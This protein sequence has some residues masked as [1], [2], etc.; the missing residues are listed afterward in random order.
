MSITP[1]TKLTDAAESNA[2]DNYHLVFAVR[3]ALELLNFSADGLKALSLEGVSKDDEKT[4]DPQSLLGVDLTEYYGGQNLTGAKAVVISQ[5]KYSTRHADRAWTAAELCKGKKSGTAG[6]VMDRLGKLFSE[7][8][9]NHPAQVKKVRV[10]LVSNRPVSTDLENLVNTLK[11]GKMPRSFATYKNKLSVPDKN[12]ADRIHK[13]T[14][15]SADQILGFLAA[16]DFSDCGSGS[17]LYQTER[18]YEAIAR[19]GDLDGATQFAKLKDLVGDRMLPGNKGNHTLY[20]TDVLYKFNFSELSDLLPVR[21]NIEIPDKLVEREQ[22]ND[23]QK[24]ILAPATK[25]LGL[26]GHAGIGKSTMM[27]SI[28]ALLPPGSKGILFDCYG[29]GAYNDADDRRHTPEYAI[30]QLCNEL[31]LKCGTPFL[32]VR[33]TNTGHLLKELKKRLTEAVGLLQAVSPGAL[34]A[35]LIDAADNSVSAAAQ[36]HTECFVTE[37]ARMG[38]PDGCRVI[39]SARTERLSTLN[40]PASAPTFQIRPFTK[41]ETVAFLAK[42]FS[43]IPPDTVTEFLQLTYG[44]PRVMAYVLEG[45]GSSLQE[46]IEFLK[47]NGKTLD[48]LFGQRIQEAQLRSGDASAIERFLRALVA[49]PS[50]V[51]ES[52]LQ[53]VSGLSNDL[54]TDLRVD[55][56][57]GL[58][59]ENGVFRFRDEDFETFL[60][61][62][63][64]VTASDYKAI[65]GILITEA[66][67][68]DYAS[69]HLGSMLA[70]AGDKT[71]LVD[72]VIDRKFLER[73]AD[74]IKN[75]EVFIE[76]VRL[77]M[78]MTDRADLEFFKLQFIAAEAAKSNELIENILIGH[79]ELAAAYGD[80]QT[81]QKLYFQ[82]GNPRWYGPA[83]FRN[84]AVF[85]R[86]KGTHD[87]ARKHLERARSW[88]NYRARLKEEE[89]DDYD[90]SGKDIAYAAEATLRVSGIDRCAKFIDSW[91]P[92][93]FGFEVFEELLKLLIA[94]ES[95]QQL[96]NWL[97]KF[98]LRA[99]LRIAAAS[100]FFRY[101]LKIGFEWRDIFKEPEKFTSLKKLP[102][103]FQ[104]KLL[105]FLEY[106][107][108]NG[109]AYA[110]AQP[111]LSLIPLVYPDRLPGFY[112]GHDDKE[113]AELDLLFR[114]KALQKYLDNGS[115]LLTDLYSERFKKA[116]AAKD[117]KRDNEEQ[118]KELDRVY[119]HLLR[120][121]DVRAKYLL[122]KSSEKVLAEEVKA[123][124]K[125]IGDD[126]EL[127]YYHEYRYLRVYD[128]MLQKLSDVIFFTKTEKVLQTISEGFDPKKT[129]NLDARLKLAARLSHR[130]KYDDFILKYLHSIEQTLQ[131]ELLP[132]SEV[133]GC[134]TRVTVIASRVSKGDGKYYFDQLVKASGE[135]DEEAYD[136]IRAIDVISQGFDFR[137]PQLAFDFAR[138][139][140]YCSLKL[141]DGE[142]FP[143][144]E[145]VKAIGAIDAT[146]LWPI[147][148]RWDH[149]NIR[150]QKEHITMATLI[151]LEKNI[152]SYQTAAAL[153]P[154]NPY[155]VYGVKKLAGPI[156]EKANAAADTSFKNA[157]TRD[158]LAAIKIHSAPTTSYDYEEKFF[159]LIKDGR[160]IDRNIIAEFHDHLAALQQLRTT[161]RSKETQYPRIKRAPLNALFR[162]Q[163]KAVK[164]DGDLDLQ[165][166]LRSLRA[167]AEKKNTYLNLDDVFAELRKLSR[168]GNEQHLLTALAAMTDEHISY[169]EFEDLIKTIIT[170]WAHLQV[171]K[172][173]RRSAFGTIV[174][175]WFPILAAYRSIDHSSL[176]RLQHFFGAS[177]AELAAVINRHFPEHLDTLPANVLYNLFRL[178]LVSLDATGRDQL[179]TWIVARWN[180]SVA[181]DMGDGTWSAGFAPPKE[182][183]KLITSYLEYLLGHPVRKLRWRA[184]HALRRAVNYKQT[185][186]IDELIT[187]SRNPAATAFYYRGYTFFSLSAR[188][189]LYIAVE[190]MVKEQPDQMMPFAAALLSELTNNDIPHA[191]IKFFLR[192]ACRFLDKTFPTIY[193]A[194]EKSAIQKELAPLKR[195]ES[196]RIP[197]YSRRRRDNQADGIRFDF[198]DTDTIPYWYESLSDALNVSMLDLLTVIDYFIT[199][200]WGFTGD[201]Y[202]LDYVKSDY[203]NTQNRHGAEPRVENLRRYYEYHGMFCAAYEILKKR[204]ASKNASRESWENWIAGWGLA[205]PDQWLADL[206]DP[207]PLEPRFW[208]EKQPGSEWEFSVQPEDFHERVRI[209]PSE[210]FLT[211]EEDSHVYFSKDREHVRIESGLVHPETAPAL[212]AALQSDLGFD[213][214]LPH[215]GIFMDEIEDDLKDLQKKFVLEHLNIQV[216]NENEGIDDRDAFFSDYDKFR[217]IPSPMVVNVLGLTISDDKRTA[218][219]SKDPADPLTHFEVW[220]NTTNDQHYDDFKTSGRRFAMKKA[221]LL[222]LLQKR[223]RCLIIHCQISRDLDRKRSGEYMPDYCLLYL[224]YPNGIA[225]TVTGSHHIR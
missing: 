63:Y 143:W 10:K 18:S 45:D 102:L 181:D 192:S 155:F 74:P 70:K 21:N 184:Q 156:I 69:I 66:A 2:G 149:R 3:K 71:E 169:S 171:L 207:I 109:I 183:K 127:R 23:L 136:Q 187:N 159:E 16:L 203:G 13:A 215:K 140:E 96:N 209:S 11:V 198:D 160:F 19:L 12:I 126:W 32:L 190:R 144:D 152:I 134:Y 179:L 191:Q 36:F 84:A 139:V 59:Y 124:V 88:M 216:N 7:L 125:A 113:V 33:N 78:R 62:T 28:D 116:L 60:R 162:K 193:T 188:L 121:Y 1:Q 37:L 112:H 222:E 14:R 76:R 114:V 170:E 151:S 93:S 108:N 50:P 130:R 213:N 196:S 205:W 163:L 30:L 103:A 217:Q 225:H 81:N 47:P 67:T 42:H 180:E 48:Q 49:L 27:F 80:L 54:M 68:N 185:M 118:K 89:Q 35:L 168:S 104:F 172:E 99:D 133:V 34:L 38:L 44:T 175:N 51:P 106:A 174:V 214:Y 41:Q 210:A 176:K 123:V 138:Y 26:H 141:G 110:D 94:S 98:P 6:S 223:K 195:T 92:K 24:L 221:A 77:A 52:F 208:T 153:M 83:H 173:W 105:S 46:K 220:N 40:L 189:N 165:E 206:R 75:K 135:V 150:K 107:L 61:T 79:A 87:L 182:E 15:L 65:A 91:T 218:Y 43:A 167:A 202:K 72:I 211:L 29:G 39:F 55:L 224:I 148:S 31:G 20:V 158:L 101:G 57:R 212:L 157:F 120:I 142:N 119:R 131:S 90:F 199:E 194:D 95:N 122:G 219:Q 82:S 73:P 53:A 201:P 128:F 146:S 178:T 132:G 8:L 145:A 204:G 129:N 58:V 115:F 64:P 117:Q 86:D 5:L 154:V 100:L 200:Q 137:K 25:V 164:I 22:L 186:L 161:T 177:D 17:S 56:W 4:F 166:V 147:L 9:K 85:S 97:R 197:G 111:F